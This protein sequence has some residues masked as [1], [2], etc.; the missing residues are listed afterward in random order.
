MMK[1]LLIFLF[2]LSALQVNACINEYLKIP[3]VQINSHPNAIELGMRAPT[4]DTSILHGYIRDM[5]KNLIKGLDSTDSDLVAAYL[6]DREYIKA[7]QLAEKLYKKFPD[8][9]NVVMNYAVALEL[10]AKYPE[11]L[12]HL[13]EGI[14]INPESHFG[15]EWIHEKIL[16]SIISESNDYSKSILDYDFGDDTIP[17]EINNKSYDLKQLEYQLNERVYFVKNNDPL[18]G[19][20]IFDLA[21]M[22]FIFENKH[23]GGMH[24]FSSE[25]YG[26]ARSFGYTSPV[27]NKR[28]KYLER[29]GLKCYPYDPVSWNRYKFRKKALFKT[30]PSE[31]KPDL[32]QTNSEKVL[33]NRVIISIG[34]FI[35]LVCILGFALLLKGKD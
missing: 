35:S 25:Q 4:I 14:K 19:S 12:V 6:Y 21:N 3:G 15:S 9:Y 26:A 30:D 24:T 2:Y 33:F 23:N 18:F 34:I 27:L 31:I 17:V 7:L 11:A 13:R 10:N 32:P 16:E 29:I 5:E 28:I 8:T 22:I 1:I 20:L